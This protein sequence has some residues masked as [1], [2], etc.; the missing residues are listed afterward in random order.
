MYQSHAAGFTYRPAY[1][2]LC[3]LGSQCTS[4]CLSFLTCNA[5]V[6]TMLTF[7]PECIKA[8]PCLQ[9]TRSTH[10]CYSGSIRCVLPVKPFLDVICHTLQEFQSRSTRPFI[11]SWVQQAFTRDLRC[12]GCSLGH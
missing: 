8:G 7:R 2:T 3:D 10:S 4:L 6:V 5:Q 11:H 9:K 12:A 1:V